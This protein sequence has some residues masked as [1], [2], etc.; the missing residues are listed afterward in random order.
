MHSACVAIHK[1]MPYPVDCLVALLK[2]VLAAGLPRKTSAPA[3]PEC[4]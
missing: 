3:S 2:S 1:D 4:I